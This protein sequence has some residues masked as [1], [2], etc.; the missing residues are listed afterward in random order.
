MVNKFPSFMRY[1]KEFNFK[2]YD[3]SESD[4]TPSEPEYYSDPN[5]V[6]SQQFYIYLFMFKAIRY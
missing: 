5:H 4:L 3:Y 2:D 1:F 6:N